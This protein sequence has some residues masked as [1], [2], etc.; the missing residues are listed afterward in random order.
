MRKASLADLGAKA[1]RA[2]QHLLV[3]NAAVDPTQEDEVDDAGHVDAGGEQI[4][5]HGDLGVGVVAEGAD[6][7][8]DAIDAA[9]DFAD[10]SVLDGNA[11][12][13]VGLLATR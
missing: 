5:R 3:E 12:L 9:G 2:A 4:D 13:G 7:R 8:T 1:R 10:G 11:R 6:Q